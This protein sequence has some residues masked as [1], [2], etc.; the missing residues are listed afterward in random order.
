M[1][2]RRY[3]QRWIRGLPVSW[4]VAHRG[5]VLNSPYQRASQLS[6]MP[7]MFGVHDGYINGPSA[8]R[9]AFLD[10]LLYVWVTR[11]PYP[12]AIYSNVGGA[13]SY[14]WALATENRDGVFYQSFGHYCKPPYN[15]WSRLGS[16]LQ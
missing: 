8:S 14:H 10:R 5:A 15:T 1:V 4:L 3:W 9:S 16:V 13:G 11:S 2:Q 7:I 6:Y 12:G